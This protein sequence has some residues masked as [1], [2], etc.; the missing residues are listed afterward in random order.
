MTFLRRMV[1]QAWG[2]LPWPAEGGDV[3]LRHEPSGHLLTDGADRHR[4]VRF[5]S[6][7]EAGAFRAR[8]LDEAAAWETLPVEQVA[9]RAA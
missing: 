6:R 1:T 9:C 4:P 8:Y 5:S 2:F 3:V 7:A